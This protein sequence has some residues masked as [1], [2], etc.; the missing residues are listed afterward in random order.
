[1]RTA[2]EAD[3]VNPDKLLGGRLLY[4]H[5]ARERFAP[6][7]DGGPPGAEKQAYIERLTGRGE[8]VAGELALG[9]GRG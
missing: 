3:R 5:C 8:R 4:I 1:M 7:V 6:N 9:N 2:R